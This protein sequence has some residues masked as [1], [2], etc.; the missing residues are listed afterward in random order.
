MANDIVLQDVTDEDMS[1]F[2]EHQ[3][4]AAACHMAAFTSKDPADRSAFDAHWARILGNEAITTK[5]ILYRGEVAG[6]VMSFVQEGKLEVTYWLGREHWGRGI[7]TCALLGLLEIVTE[8]PVYARA[9]KDN[10]ASLRVLEKCGFTIVGEDRGFAN[11]RGMEIE[12]FVL[13]LKG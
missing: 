9:S 5:T 8:R 12:E 11:A 7:A 1:A 4:D 10:V 3:Q 13:E 2:F 6:H